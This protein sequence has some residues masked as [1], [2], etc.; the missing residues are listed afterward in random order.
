MLINAT[1]FIGE[2]A[3]IGR[4]K[5]SVLD[6]LDVFIKKYE[7]KFLIELLGE[8]VASDFATALAVIPLVAPWIDLKAKL[9]DSDTKESPIANY[10]YYW[11]MRNNATTTVGLGEAIADAENSRIV[12]NK[13]KMVRAWSEMRVWIE[14]NREWFKDFYTD[15][16]FKGGYYSS[17][18][19]YFY[20]WNNCKPDPFGRINTFNI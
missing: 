14:E 5:A 16:D 9:A 1:Y 4:D 19:G 18:G 6:L 8:D 11:Y 20:G 3:V 2:I 7:K 15:N 10:I 12:D 17:Y 13:D